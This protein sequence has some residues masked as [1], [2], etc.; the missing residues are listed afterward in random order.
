MAHNGGL[1]GEQEVE[2]LQSLWK[3]T[4]ATFKRLVADGKII[5]DRIYY[6]G[7][8][9]SD[10]KGFA[11]SKKGQIFVGTGP[12]TYV[13]FASSSDDCLPRANKITDEEI[14]RIVAGSDVE[15]ADNYINNRGLKSLWAYITAAANDIVTNLSAMIAA[16]QDAIS[17]TTKRDTPTDNETV[18]MQANGSNDTKTF[19][20]RKMSD[21]VSYFKNKFDAQY[22]RIGAF[23]QR[24]NTF[25]L[26]SE[27][28]SISKIDNSLYAADKRFIVT[29]EIFNSDTG[30]KVTDQSIS[31]LFDGGY[32][33][34]FKHPITGEYELITIKKDEDGSG[35]LWTYGGGYLYVSFYFT[36][37]PD[38]NGVSIRWKCKNSTDWNSGTLTKIQTKPNQAVFY[39]ELKGNHT[40][41]NTIEIKVQGKTNAEAAWP[42]VSVTEIEFIRNRATIDQESA[43]VKYGFA[44]EIYGSL[45]APKFITKGGTS[46]QIHNGDGSLSNNLSVA[47]GGTGATTA[48]GAEFN[49]L[50]QVQDIDATLN[51]N[52]KIALCNETKSSTNGVFRWLKMSNVWNYIKGKIDSAYSAVLGSGITSGKVSSYDMHIAD[53]TKHTTSAEKAT[54]NG[55]ADAVHTHTKGQVG[56][57]N[58]DNTSDADKPIST[59]QQAALDNI[60]TEIQGKA[61]SSHT[62]SQGQITGLSSALSAKANDNAVVHLAGG[63]RITGVKTFTR[64]VMAEDGV[65]GT[66]NNTNYGSGLRFHYEESE[67]GSKIPMIAVDSFEKTSGGGSTIALHYVIGGKDAS[68]KSC[69]NGRSNILPS[70]KAI[71]EALQ[72]KVGPSDLSEYYKKTD[73]VEKAKKANSADFA[74]ASEEAQFDSGGNEIV[75]TYLKKSGGAMTGDLILSDG[76]IKTNKLSDGQKLIEYAGLVK[77]STQPYTGRN[78]IGANG[79]NA[80]KIQTIIRSGGDL[81]HRRGN[82]VTKEDAVVIDSTNASEQL[83]SIVK[84]KVFNNGYACNVD[85]AGH[86]YLLG[87]ADVADMANMDYSVTLLITNG[88]INQSAEAGILKI[89]ARNNNIGVIYAVNVQWIL[90]PQISDTFKT[91]W[92]RVYYQNQANKAT[93]QLWAYI[94][95]QYNS[96]QVD[97]LTE[98]SRATRRTFRWVCSETLTQGSP[99]GTGYVSS[100]V[101]KIGNPNT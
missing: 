41:I 3:G 101:L 59:A 65:Y 54:W 43:V 14:G 50:N 68:N 40:Y 80:D 15:S 31:S 22:L 61:N 82:D 28:I 100:T 11:G 86:W 89:H 48:I 79:G 70:G 37:I 35:S 30:E 78:L 66:A 17:V 27:K 90:S 92:F 75:T 88:Y 21:V 99:W 33:G 26:E 96:Y 36:K 10:E 94:R 45:T 76:S 8:S 42:G 16:K 1:T 13:E 49:I 72:E 5:K 71:Y 44:Q 73:T 32:E 53:V 6:V 77:T 95:N 4:R 20:R 67:D 39:Y 69:I 46:S 29:R 18:I 7:N 55:K 93:L 81:I 52:R 47:R 85:S 24:N 2:R 57:G 19:L 58:V 25:G 62:H 60:E 97:V 9:D 91:D 83:D 64:E 87:S 98:H 51:D 38:D 23:V 34:V 12:K 56:L 84:G 74:S 63:E